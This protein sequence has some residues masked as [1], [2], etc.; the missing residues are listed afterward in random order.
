MIILLVVQV[1]NYVIQKI[2]VFINIPMIIIVI[3]VVLINITHM[4]NYIMIADL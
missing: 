3:N 1:I 2:I 4:T